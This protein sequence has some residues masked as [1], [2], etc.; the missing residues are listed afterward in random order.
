MPAEDEHRKLPALM[1]T[2]MVGYSALPQR[3]EALARAE[4]QHSYYVIWW[5]VDPDLDPSRSAP[6]FTE[7]LEQVGLDQ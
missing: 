7:L 5:K 3:N 2:D 4:D 6:C 1:F